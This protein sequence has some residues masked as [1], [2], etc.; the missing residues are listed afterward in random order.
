MKR[1]TNQQFAGRRREVVRLAR[2]AHTG[3]IQAALARHSRLPFY[4]SANRTRDARESTVLM[5]KNPP[6]AH[7]SA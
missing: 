3:G 5:R 4:P 7:Q 2:L 6:F 1:Q